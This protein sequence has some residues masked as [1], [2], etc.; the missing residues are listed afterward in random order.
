MKRLDLAV[1]SDG[2]PEAGGERDDFT[3][4][5]DA[6]MISECETIKDLCDDSPEAEAALAG[7]WA[8]LWKGSPAD[9]VLR[10]HLAMFRAIGKIAA[11]V[12]WVLGNHDAEVGATDLKRRNIRMVVK[13]LHIH[14]TSK[15]SQWLVMHGHEGDPNRSIWRAVGKGACK[16]LGWLGRHVSARLEDKAHAW[17]SSLSSGSE[18]DPLRY[19]R[20]CVGE[21]RRLGCQ[22][23]IFGHTHRAGDGEIDGIRWIDCGTWKRDGWVMLWDDGSFTRFKGVVNEPAQG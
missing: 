5:D 17:A 22:G 16:A 10:A 12:V 4:S 7:D 13:K 11:F 1:C 20:Y 23:V 21:A 2:H 14:R 19:A 3:P 9:A 8:E 6:R 15:G 18:G